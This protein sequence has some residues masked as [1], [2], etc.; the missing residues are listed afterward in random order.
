MIKKIVLGSVFLALGASGA[1]A[2]TFSNYKWKGDMPA[3]KEVPT[4]FSSADAV[5][6]DKT[7]YSRGTFSGE[8]PYIEQLGTYRTQN[9][10][11]ILNK[12]GLEAFNKV[13]VQKFKGRLA[14]YVQYK[15]VDVRIR[16]ADGTVKDY[17]VSDLALFEPKEGDDYY[18]SRDNLYIY[19]LKDLEV[20]DELELVNVIESKFL[21]QGRTVTL[22]DAYPVLSSSFTLSVPKNIKVKG[23]NYNIASDLKIPNVS[24]TSTNFVY[25]WVLKD[26]PALPEADAFGTNLR[27]DKV[28]H[29]IYEL[30]F[31]ALR[32]DMSFKVKNWS[33]LFTQY[34]NDGLDVRIRKKK[35]LND[36]YANLFAEGAKTMGKEAAVL[37]KLEKAFLMN[38]F[39]ATKLQLVNKLEEFEKSEGIDYFLSNKKTSYRNL[40]H[41]YKDFFERFEIEYFLVA[42]KD[43]LSGEIDQSYISSVQLSSYFFAFKVKE[44]VFTVSGMDGFNE[45]PWN[46]YGTKCLMKNIKDRKSE[47]QNLN[48]ATDE[49]KSKNNKRI[50]KS[51]ISVDFKANSLAFKQKETA[52]GLYSSGLRSGI[53]TPSKADTL[54]KA[55]QGR[56]DNAYRLDEKVKAT[57][58][59]A[60]V[61]K[62]STMAPFLFSY[63][64]DVK[65]DGV[66][67]KEAKVHKIPADELLSPSIRWASNA[68]ERK[69]NFHIPFQGTVKETVIMRL[70][71]PAKLKNI[72][73]F[74]VSKDNEFVGFRSVCKQ[75]APNMIQLTTIYAV[76]TILVPTANVKVYNAVNE[77][78]KELTEENFEFV[79]D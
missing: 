14:D 75:V 12:E 42:G 79:L 8:F 33:D 51:I 46:L 41:I 64:Y 1:F 22:H 9:H 36:F 62:F 18:A 5:Y 31:D 39:V 21:D 69:L 77:L 76:K 30:N 3:S 2:Q 54:D 15:F 34:A 60:K 58:S 4:D 37:S 72:D 40:M 44:G 61:T 70:A 78:V 43:R 20:G 53:V 25:K 63:G 38:E 26:L 17:S 27:E 32:S 57:V 68:E 65:L 50:S 66:I 11:K 19:E 28:E 73:R 71:Q 35:K 52:K 29:F 67:E 49:L 48:F 74:N 16:K 6:F 55:L 56:F 24:K 47:L 13:V 23:N 45:L 59:N 10:I 7:V